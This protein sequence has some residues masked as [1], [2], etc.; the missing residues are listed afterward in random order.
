M[1]APNYKDENK[2]SIYLCIGILNAGFM[3]PAQLDC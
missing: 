3:Q 1:F 2:L